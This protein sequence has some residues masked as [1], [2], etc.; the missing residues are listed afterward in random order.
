MLILIVGDKEAERRVLREACQRLGHEWR[1]ASDGDAGWLQYL[2]CR[3]Q[4]ILSDFVMPGKNGLE[5]CRA[6]RNQPFDHYTYYV[7]LST[8]AQREH[9]LDGLR[10]GADD[11]LPK[12][13]DVEDLELRLLAAQR[14]TELHARLAEQRHQLQVMSERLFEESRRD[15]LTQVGNRLRYHDDSPKFL[16]LPCAVALCDIDCFKQ[17]ND[18]YGH[19]EGDKILRLVAGQLDRL[20]GEAHVY[21]F[22]GEEFLLIFPGLDADSAFGELEKLRRE[23]EALDVVHVG[24]KPFGK[25]TVT[26]GLCPLDGVTLGDLE[27]AGKQ[28]DDALYE[29]KRSGRNRVRMYV[30]A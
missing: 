7:L 29:G 24:N 18:I 19:L 9:I 15:P 8:L 25:L 13:V 23:I 26:F 1:E 30:P 14:V 3:P 22:G 5:L 27:R 6:V 16:E 20:S 12:P 10:S 2:N 28:A 17:Y 21:R 11:Y 4:V